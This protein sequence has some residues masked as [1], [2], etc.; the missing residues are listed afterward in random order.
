MLGTHFSFN[1]TLTNTKDATLP[2]DDIEFC[3]GFGVYEHIRLRKGAIFFL[4]QHAK[5]LLASADYINLA[6]A[7]SVEQ[8]VAY[9]HEL[10]KKNK[11]DTANIK[12]L[13]IGGNKP[14]LYIFELAPRFVEKKIYT[15]GVSVSTT[16]YERYLPKAKTLNMLPSY[17]IYRDAKK[18][19]AY[20]AL[21][22][23][24][25]GN[26]H[27]GTRSNF[28][29]IKNNTLYTPPLDTVLEGVTRQTVIDCAT[30]HGY[31]IEEQ[32]IPLA[33]IFDYDGAFLTNTSGKIMPIKTIDTQSFDTIHESISKLR[34][35]YNTYLEKAAQHIL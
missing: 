15:Q 19:G 17:L 26:V 22:Y 3:Y 10:I 2:I 21:L 18:N 29:T 30:Q 33:S 1:G 35:A 27:E 13:L 11:I 7:F 23:D 25:Q 34:T 24:T 20:D 4:E 31:K 16:Q 12:M 5:R 6:H 14:R 9:T 8:I 32:S 28:F